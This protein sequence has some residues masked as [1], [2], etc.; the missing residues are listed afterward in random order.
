MQGKHSNMKQSRPTSAC[1]S[2]I[3]IHVTKVN[4]IHT[5]IVHISWEIYV[6]NQHI[7]A[8]CRYVFSC[9][10]SNGTSRFSCS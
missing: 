4:Y 3:A 10:M 2:L 9:G 6:Y 7:F 8:D 1:A 5:V